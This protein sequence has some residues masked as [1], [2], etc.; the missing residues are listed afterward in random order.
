M[1][2]LAVR[3]LA[4]RPHQTVLMLLGFFF[5]TAAFVSLSGIMLG[6]RGYLVYQLINNDDHLH[7][8]P[9]EEFLFDHSLDEAF[10][11]RAVGRVVWDA[12]PSGRKD[13]ATVQDPQAWYERLRADA[14]VVAYTP[15]LTAAVI[16]SKAKA[17]VSATLIGCDALAQL[18]VTTIGDYVTEGRFSDIAAGG[19][20]LAV[21]SELM[22]LLGLRLSQNVTVALASGVPEPFKVSAVFSTGNRVFD[23][24]A[25]ASIADVQRVNRTPNQVNKIAVRTRDHARAAA[26][27]R[28]W[29][30][31]GSD[32]V[33][34]WDQKNAN[35]FQVFRIQDAV[36]FLSIGA[37]M[38]V[39]G[40]GIYNILNMTVMQKRR[41]VAILRSMGWAT[42]DVVALF[43]VQGLILGFS[44]IALGLSFGFGLSFYLETIPLGEGPFGGG[45]GH[46]LVSRAPSI[47][48]Q[49]A[50]LAL[51]STLLASVL[52]ARAAGRLSP[53]EIIRR[54]AE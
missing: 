45:V 13:S 30:A 33:E 20:R 28:A 40:F 26:M 11:P 8:E 42:R 7:I 47:Y 48:L 54:G 21:G 43:L 44:G 18:R 32:K 50:L 1:I 36:R 10:Y 24:A 15:Q 22:R 9:R 46:L 31:L 2:F 34:S 25:Y 39:A 14:R 27:A 38:V 41:D 37:I 12:P 3:Y 51:A 16:F 23:R 17:T 6:F 35:I 29:A 19:N 53:I 5:G 49:A 52:P 4:A